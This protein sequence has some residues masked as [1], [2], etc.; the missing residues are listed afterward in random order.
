MALDQSEAG[1]RGHWDGIPL[2]LHGIDRHTKYGAQPLS[3]YYLRTSEMVGFVS[4]VKWFPL[5][6]S[7]NNIS[8]YVI[9][10]TR[11]YYLPN[12]GQKPTT[13]S[14]F[15]HCWYV[16]VN[17]V[18]FCPVQT[19]LFVKSGQGNANA[20]SP[21]AKTTFP[22]TVKNCM[23]GNVNSNRIPQLIS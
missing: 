20:W 23:R 4:I 3:I 15:H 5:T 19:R 21:R 11:C 7:K 22:K 9:P 16:T 6:A 2:I 8:Y 17:D 10:V 14:E 18:I 1:I 12:V 13:S